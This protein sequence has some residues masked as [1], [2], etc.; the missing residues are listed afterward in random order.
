MNPLRLIFMGSPDF[1]V[2]V[3][4]ALIRADHEI[5]CVYAQPPR[6][7]GRGQQEKRCAVHA[8]AEDGGIVVR[9]PATLKAP[10]DQAAFA[11]LEADA[12]IVVAYGLILPT[13]V[14]DAPRLGCLNVHA[15]L[16]PRWR[17]AA[18][19]QRAILAGDIESGVS[20]MQI[21]EG[22]DTGDVLLRGIIPITDETTAE[23]LHDALIGLGAAL[24]VEALDG[25]AAGTV[26]STPQPEDGVT[27]AA[28]LT[29]DEGRLDWQQPAVELQRQVRAL[30]PWPG[31]WFDHDGGRIKVLAADVVEAGGNESPGTL[32]DGE[33]AV[34]C[35]EGVL[36][37]TEVQRA[38]KARQDAS[39]FV[40]GFSMPPGMV[41]E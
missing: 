12:C 31:V 20:I 38:G 18:P 11:A 17:G 32:I 8:F 23:T 7:A 33:L 30:N 13:A 3:L 37:L 9:T 39:A 14:L 15:S 1:S 21:D 27:Y 22:L 24:M 40:R 10:E 26:T 4:E 28:K 41:L 19:I 16:L 36:R 34:A 35:G 6:P 2:P 5:V 29:R 25:L